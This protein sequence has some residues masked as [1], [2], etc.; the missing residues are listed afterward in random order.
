[1]EPSGL[2]PEIFDKMRA[3]FQNY[4]EIDSVVLYGSRAMGNFKKASDID[5]SLKGS[6]IDSTLQNKIEFDLDDL[7]LPYK[8]DV[9]HYNSITNPEFLKHINE[10][11]SE[12]Y[13]K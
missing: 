2:T 8:F 7:M 9:S 4:T 6:K 1:M 5:I 10:V 12:I 11:G 13:K 3:V